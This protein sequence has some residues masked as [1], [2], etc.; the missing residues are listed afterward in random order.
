MNKDD[1]VL[2]CFYSIKLNGK[3]LSQDRRECIQSIT[4]DELDDGSDTMTLV[5]S[6][7]E[8]KYI[9]DNIFIEEV[10]VYAQT[11]WW[12]E[13]HRRTFKGYISAIDISFPEEGYPQ[14]S[15]MCLDNSHRM[16]RKK[17][18]RSW[19]NVTRA[20]V[21][22]KIA[23]EYGFK[24]IVQKGYKFTKEDTISQSG[25][26]DIEF[27]ENLASEERD[28]F[29][30]KLIGD[31]LYYVKKGLLSSSSATVYY[32]TK[33]YDVLSFSPK[34]N[35]ETRKEE[36]ESAD[37]N[38]DSKTTDSAVASDSTTSR[39]VQGE[40]VKPSS[41]PSNVSSP[42]S[43]VSRKYNPKTGEWEKVIK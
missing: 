1:K 23:Q 31:T 20:D 19:D 39:G 13:T 4:F 15:I 25:V 32:K 9:E 14:L 22:K 18:T 28:L 17:K 7:P 33:D 34:I 8:F 41:S 35:K 29:K 2:S 38:T 40:S 5:V 36:I 21:V 16:N 24:C 42:S 27:C 26:T 3:A 10:P 11:G 6:D 43:S 37:V 30:C 12:G